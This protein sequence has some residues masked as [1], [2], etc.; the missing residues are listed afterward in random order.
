MVAARHARRTRSP[1]FET[2]AHGA[3]MYVQSNIE[4]ET[5]NILPCQLL[6]AMINTDRS[7]LSRNL[8]DG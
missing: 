3:S 2:D 8:L 7:F 5:L 1:H 4:D 6:D